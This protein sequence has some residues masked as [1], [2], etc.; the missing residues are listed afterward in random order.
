MGLKQLPKCKRKECIF[1]RNNKYCTILREKPKGE[2]KFY[3]N[4]EWFYDN[5]KTFLRYMR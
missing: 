4:R 3:K 5:N 2:C 1:C